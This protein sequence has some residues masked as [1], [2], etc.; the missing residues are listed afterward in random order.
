MRNRFDINS[1][2]KRTYIT[3]ITL[4]NEMHPIV[5]TIRSI[6]QVVHQRC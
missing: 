3:Q 4:S 1:K 6:Y 5:K 2:V